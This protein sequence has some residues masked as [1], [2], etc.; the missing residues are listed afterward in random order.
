M[1][2]FVAGRLK[3]YLPQWQKITTDQS[4]L[5]CVTGY[6]IE[7]DEQKPIIYSKSK[8]TYT[9][10]NKSE[11]KLLELELEKLLG[12]QVLEE[13]FHTEGEFISP[14]FLTPKPDGS[15]RMILNLKNLNKS[16]KYY[17]FKMDT[18]Q[19]AL[20]LMEPQGF[21]ASIDLKDAYY[22]VP[23]ANTS[24]KYLRFLY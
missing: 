10:L 7:F 17:H 13:T 16:V 14:V 4:I 15:F 8:S 6:E 22:S 12:K 20:R 21:M 23:V 18:L 11:E 24:R 5:T 19:A 1:S 3:Y 2:S 9:P